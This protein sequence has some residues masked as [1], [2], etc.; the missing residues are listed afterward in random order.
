MSKYYYRVRLEICLKTDETILGFVNISHIS[1]K[2]F[3]GIIICCP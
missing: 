2:K 1:Y 3:E